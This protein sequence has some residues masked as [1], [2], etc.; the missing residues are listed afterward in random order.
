MSE[1]STTSDAAI[2]E[3]F[4]G[5]GGSQTP[6]SVSDS[7]NPSDTMTVIDSVGTTKTD[8]AGDDGDNFGA[9][10]GGAIGGVVIGVLLLAGIAWLIVRK[11]NASN[12]NADS[13]G[14]SERAGELF[15]STTRM[16][17]YG[18]V[19]GL[20]NANAIASRNQYESTSAPL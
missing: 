17:E 19:T 4:T 7:S 20:V 2:M 18:S 8:A 16:H 15:A 1:L 6:E 13:G 10:V 9:V 5:M 14:S 12:L 3:T 11:R